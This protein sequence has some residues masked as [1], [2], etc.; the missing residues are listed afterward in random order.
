MCR[1]LIPSVA[2]LALA[3]ISFAQQTPISSIYGTGSPLLHVEQLVGDQYSGFRHSCLLVYADGRYHRE[4]RRQDHTNGRASEDWLSPEVFEGGILA[5]D[6]QRLN[7]IVESDGFRSINGTVGDPAIL[8][9]SIVLN[10]RTDGVTPEHDLDILEASIAHSNG[11]QGFEVYRSTPGLREEN[12]LRLF[13]SWVGEVEKRK[14]VRLDKAAANNCATTSS[15]RGGSLT[16]ASTRLFARPIYTPGPDSSVSGRDAKHV[17]TVTVRILVNGD[18]SVG[19]V[20]VKRGIDP[21]L[22]RAALESVRKWKFSP[23]RLFG[24]AV[25]TLMDVEVRFQ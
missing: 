17:G 5:D 18:G 3:G 20:T 7:E 24:M 19:P 11:L 9:E 16:E 22:D 2:A 10:L 1:V 13:V 8:R 4:I 23:A 6:L 25:P 15:P 12:S 14:E 21:V